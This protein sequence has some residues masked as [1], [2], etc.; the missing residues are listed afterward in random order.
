MKKIPESAL[1]YGYD[2]AQQQG[3]ELATEGLRV[4]LAVKMILCNVVTRWTSC[5]RRY[6]TSVN[7]YKQSDDTL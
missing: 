5:S 3:V 1:T 6:V 4:R 7:K 2:V